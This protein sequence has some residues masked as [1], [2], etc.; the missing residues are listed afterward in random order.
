MSLSSDLISDTI[1]LPRPTSCSRLLYCSSE[2]TY[3][4]ALK[5]SVSMFMSSKGSTEASA[6]APL[7]SVVPP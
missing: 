1:E 3:F 7:A 2:P 5:P 4:G 6:G